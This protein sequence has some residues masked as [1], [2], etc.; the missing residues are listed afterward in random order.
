MYNKE[1]YFSWLKE[2]K[3]RKVRIAFV[4]VRFGKWKESLG[5][6]DPMAESDYKL[7]DSRSWASEIV[8]EDE[9]VS[10]EATQSKSTGIKP[11]RHSKLPKRKG[12]D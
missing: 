12:R 8:L 11:Q 3:R 4:P 5:R 10:H 9:T 1:D 7:E 2:M 6:D